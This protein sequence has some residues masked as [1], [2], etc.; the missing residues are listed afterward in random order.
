MSMKW[1]L[2]LFGLM[3]AG[4]STNTDQVA[5]SNPPAPP[6]TMTPSP[7]PTTPATSG[8]LIVT[9]TNFQDGQPVPAGPT[10]PVIQW[11]GVPPT[12]KSISL[13]VLDPDA[14]N[15][16]HWLVADMP[17]TANEVSG[18]TPGVNGEGKNEYHPPTPPPGPV[19]HY[20]F[21]VYAL[22][23]MLA[24]KP[25]FSDSDLQNAMTGHIV[26]QGEIVGTFQVSK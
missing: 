26:G 15:F 9:S 8:I 25:G 3:A 4:C 1:S 10:P 23:T 17:P 20:H 18:G 5:A 2:L 21:K 13:E 6:A 24:L 22:D 14:N 16:V 19:H 11:A 12:A 7:S